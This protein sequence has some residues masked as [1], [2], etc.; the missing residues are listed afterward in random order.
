MQGPNTEAPS[1]RPASAGRKRHDPALDGVRGL[2]ILIVMIH[3]HTV[4]RGI[5]LADL[6]VAT[7]LHLGGVGLFFV[8]SGYL[9][10]GILLD[11]KG[12]QGY[13]KSFYVRRM[14]RIFPLYYAVLILALLILPNINHAKAA[15]FGRIAGDEWSYWVFLQNY[16]IARADR[17]RH[18]LLDV[19]WTLSIEEQF[20]L[21]WPLIVWACSRRALLRITLG[22][23]VGAL[24]FRFYMCF[25][26]GAGTITIFV[27]TL[28][29]IDTLAAGSLFAIMERGPQ[30]PPLATVP[31]TTTAPDTPTTPN[32]DS[33]KPILDRLVPWA[34][35][36][37]IPLGLLAAALA[38]FENLMQSI[39]IDPHYFPW[40]SRTINYTFWTTWFAT[41]M[42]LAM[43]STPGSFWRAFW[44]SRFMRTF[45]KYSFSL[46]LFHTPLRALVRDRI[47]GPEGTQ[48]WIKFPIIWGSEIPAQIIFYIVTFPLVLAAAWVSYT[49]WEKPFLRLKKF[50]PVPKG[51]AAD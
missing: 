30:E 20:Y 15:N 28:C 17:F 10:T 4:M 41:I 23:F 33:Q 32:T 40:I 36:V 42:L 16:T 5:N 46:Y 21:V 3:H 38:T 51:T 13:F 27:T 14:L 45:G 39:P 12:G 44:T 48:A 8:L 29:R 18:A 26:V 34:K 24:L 35:W 37:G 1:I 47:Y 43:R 9:I 31:V 11:S 19:T 22:L 2:A 25:V 6:S 7:V 50:A 49:F